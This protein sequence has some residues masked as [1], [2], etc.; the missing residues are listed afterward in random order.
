MPQSIKK[1]PCDIFKTPFLSKYRQTSHSSKKKVTLPTPVG[2]D[3]P[4]LHTPTLSLSHPFATTNSALPFSSSLPS[5]RNVL[6]F[7]SC[8]LLLLVRLA[9][10]ANLIPSTTTRT[11]AEMRKRKERGDMAG[12]GRLEEEKRR[13]LGALSEESSSERGRRSRWGWRI[14]PLAVRI[15]VDVFI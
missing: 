6:F 11:I 14:T 1:P 10:K 13:L 12:R 5:L 9:K 2:H 8:P 15:F 3:P 4:T 7:R